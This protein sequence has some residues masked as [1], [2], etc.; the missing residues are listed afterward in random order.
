[1]L[2]LELAGFWLLE[3]NVYENRGS[4]HVKIQC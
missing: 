1:M 3:R 2:A 4:I